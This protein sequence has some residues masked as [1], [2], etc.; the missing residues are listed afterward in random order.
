ME[1]KGGNFLAISIVAAAIIIGG[2]FIYSAGLKNNS[3]QQ[4]NA[5]KNLGN[6]GAPVLESPQIDDD[7]VLGDENAPVTVFVFG[8]YQCPYCGKFFHETE[9]L[10]VKNYVD[11]GKVKL[12]YKDMTFLGE[13]SVAAAEA[14]ECARDQK[15]YWQFHDAL[16]EIEYQE[17]LKGN[18]EGNGNLNR[19]T[20]EKIASGLGMDT[21]EF[22]KCFDSKKYES[23][24]RK[25]NE[26]A[27][28]VMDRVSSPTIFVDGAM[29]QGAQPYDVFRSAIES[30]LAEKK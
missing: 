12:V 26:E 14:A 2:S 13:E 21:G 20:F 8:D 7:V 23:E 4:A 28:K 29:I 22:L 16:Y 18:N 25:D 6:N 19:A 27:G 24:V 30:A 1:N 11:A 9:S 3:N 17:S 5:G 10:I 15:K